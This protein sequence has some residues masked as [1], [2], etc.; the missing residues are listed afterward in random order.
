VYVIVCSQTFSADWYG[1]FIALLGD[2]TYLMSNI[3]GCA[4]IA[5][6][7]ANMKTITDFSPPLYKMI[8]TGYCGSLTTFSSWV[9]VGTTN[10]IYHNFAAVLTM[11]AMEF[12]LTWCGYELGVLAAHLGWQ[13]M[14]YIEQPDD[15]KKVENVDTNL[16]QQLALAHPNTASG[17]SSS[18]PPVDATRNPLTVSLLDG[19]DDVESKRQSKERTSSEL[20]APFAHHDNNS[21]VAT[22][23]TNNN[24]TNASGKGTGSRGVS[25]DDVARNVRQQSRSAV[26]SVRA[27]SNIAS[28]A[29]KKHNEA[30]WFVCFMITAIIMYAIAINDMVNSVIKHTDDKQLFFSIIIGPVGAWLRWWLARQP[31]LTNY[32]P[33]LKIP[34]LLANEVAVIAV[35]SINLFA[36]KSAYTGAVT[37]GV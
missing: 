24:N 34:T 17:R 22:N 8:T 35:A 6:A 27:V 18:Q 5:F 25:F 11:M 26:E 7:F 1:P 36:A 23:N 2:Q 4:I 19:S 9:V 33:Q 29:I 21:T 10:G 12:A 16:K 28:V 15:D 30:F 31:A 13:F 37:A 20:N 3:V 14:E 32:R